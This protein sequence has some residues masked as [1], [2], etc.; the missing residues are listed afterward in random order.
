MKNKVF[1]GD[2]PCD[3]CGTKENI[4]WFTDNVFWNDILSPQ[5]PILCINCFV[6]KAEK[7]YN[8]TGWRLMP[9]FPW[10]LNKK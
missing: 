2:N 7:K 6:K 1:Y 3:E 10:K 5:N 4:V 9:E 8:I